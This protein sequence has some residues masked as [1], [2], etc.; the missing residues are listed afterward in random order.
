MASQGASHTLASSHKRFRQ[1]RPFSLAAGP[2]ISGLNWIPFGDHPLK[3]DKDMVLARIVVQERHG[4][5]RLLAT[6]L[7]HRAAAQA[8]GISKQSVFTCSTA[9]QTPGTQSAAGASPKSS[10]AVVLPSASRANLGQ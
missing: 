7:H 8:A 5:A 4:G 6:P 3:L 2:N 1:H 9:K 10:R